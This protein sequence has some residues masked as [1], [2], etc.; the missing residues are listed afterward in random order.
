LSSSPTSKFYHFESA[1]RDAEAKFNAIFGG[2][3]SKTDQPLSEDAKRK[4]LELKV[5]VFPNSV[6]KI[7]QI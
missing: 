4:I 1:I 5:W 2:D 6:R 3:G 7:A